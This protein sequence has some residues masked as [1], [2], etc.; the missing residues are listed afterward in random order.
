M[1]DLNIDRRVVYIA[2]LYHTGSTLLDLSLGKHSELIGLGEI[3]KALTD[4]FERNC[5]CGVDIDLCEFWGP[6]KEKIKAS[7]NLSA[8]ERYGIVVD[9]FF[10][11]YPKKILVDSSK[12]APNINLM[13]INDIEAKGIPFYLERNINLKLIYM[14]RDVRSWSSAIV[15]R[16]L[17]DSSQNSLIRLLIRNTYLRFMQWCI[18]HHKIIRYLTKYKIDFIVVRYEDFS[19]DPIVELKRISDFLGVDFQEALI[20]PNGSKSHIAVGNPMKS[21]QSSLRS[22]RYDNKWISQDN[23]V[24][25]YLVFWPLVKYINKKLAVISKG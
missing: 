19:I 23:W 12:M 17:R 22:I 6:I 15:K 3:H 20:T 10:N 13:Q 2:G 14:V 5:S 21:R 11:K 8:K 4:N 7:N 18:S 25:P 1:K 24:L 16:D 9:Y